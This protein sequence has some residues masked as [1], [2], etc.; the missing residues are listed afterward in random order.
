MA[1][2]SSVHADLPLW[3]ETENLYPRSFTDDDS[4]GCSG[5]VKF[6][7]WKLTYRSETNEPDADA[8][9][10]EWLKIYN[11]GVFHCAYGFQWSYELKDLETTS[12]KLG[13]FVELG[14]VDTPSG[15]MDL[16]AMQSGFSPG[17]DYIFVTRPNNS[18]PNT[19]YEVL[20]IQCPKKYIRA[21]GNIDIFRTDYCSINN[22][23]SMRRFAKRMA[24][25]PPIGKLEYVQE[26]IK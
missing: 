24:K 14:L 21:A 1:Q 4:F 12:A 3:I 11:Y 5:P 25:L 18:N 2:P 13:H 16:W 19:P 20:D 26:P 9:D 22:K 6:G 15:K 10:V 7:N 17:S 8:P 23:R